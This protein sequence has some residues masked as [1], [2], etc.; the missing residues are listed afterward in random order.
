MLM[1]FFHRPQQFHRAVNGPPFQ[2]PQGPFI[3]RPPHSYGTAY[4][5]VSSPSTPHGDNHSTTVQHGIYGPI[6][7]NMPHVSKPHTPPP[8]AHL[9]DMWIQHVSAPIGSHSHH[10]TVNFPP[11]P[12]P[13]LTPQGQ[14]FYSSIGY[15]PGPP[16]L[17]IP[18]DTG[19][20]PK[21]VGS[22]VGSR[23]G[24]R[25]WAGHEEQSPYLHH[26]EGNHKRW[27]VPGFNSSHHPVIPLHP[28]WGQQPAPGRAMNP[29]VTF[30]P[31]QPFNEE[32]GRSQ[33]LTGSS[34]LTLNDAWGP[35]WS[36]L[37]ATK[38]P[39]PSRQTPPN[40]TPPTSSLPPV[41]L[42]FSTKPAS[43]VSKGE[44]SSSSEAW[45]SRSLESIAAPTGQPAGGGDQSTRGGD[46]SGSGGN[47][48]TKECDQST[49]SEDLQRLLKS[50]D[51]SN[52]HAHALKVCVFVL[53]VVKHVT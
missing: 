18:S 12:P 36:S 3:P 33:L 20:S 27:S 49:R 1:C 5:P 10:N 39:A 52:E 21:P 15:N 41:S 14:S 8:N 34:S 17:M 45:L 40:R 30:S 13:S 37:P 22:Q 35:P 6:G 44:G 25:H 2:P 53:Y 9:G 7:S 11:R 42:S 51:I 24:G 16:Q 32:G 26:W 29:G 4:I 19:H 43:S 38:P 28:A 48:S 31:D 47:Q 46:Q 23:G 50:L